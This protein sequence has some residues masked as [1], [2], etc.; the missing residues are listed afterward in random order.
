MTP[1]MKHIPSTISA[2]VLLLAG[3]VH[4]AAAQ[5]PMDPEPSPAT[6]LMTDCDVPSL[7]DAKIDSCLERARVL[8]ETNPSPD[9]DLLTSKLEQRSAQRFDPNSIAPDQTKGPKVTLDTPDNVTTPPTKMLDTDAAKSADEPPVQ[10]SEDDGAKAPVQPD[11]SKID[12]GNPPDT[13]TDDPPPPD[14]KSDE[15]P[16]RDPGA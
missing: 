12:D 10:D 5:N 16:V 15:P 8:Q 7:E 13:N 3:A 2:A 1:I 9:I 4:P 14:T 11:S 6:L